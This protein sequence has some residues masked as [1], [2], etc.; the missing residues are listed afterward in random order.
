VRTVSGARAARNHLEHLG[1]T[2][3]AIS[4]D[5]ADR[6]TELGKMTIIDSANPYDLTKG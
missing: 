4:L 1:D 6:L 5:Q 3:A 2:M